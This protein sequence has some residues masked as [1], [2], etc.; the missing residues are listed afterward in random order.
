MSNTL[1]L[2]RDFVILEFFLFFSSKINNVEIIL[3]KVSGTC[4]VHQAQLKFQDNFNP[5]K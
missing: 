2:N 5:M 1:L 3:S 4:I